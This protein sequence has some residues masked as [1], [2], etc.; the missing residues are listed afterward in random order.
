MTWRPALPQ[1]VAVRVAVCV[2]VC[3]LIRPGALLFCCFFHGLCATTKG[4]QLYAS[5]KESAQLHV[6]QHK[7]TL[8]CV[9]FFSFSFCLCRCHSVWCCFRMTYL[10][11]FRSHAS[12]I[13]LQSALCNKKRIEL[14]HLFGA[15][16]AVSWLHW[17]L[18]DFAVS[19][20]HW[21]LLAITPQAKP[22]GYITVT[23]MEDKSSGLRDRWVQYTNVSVKRIS[24][25]ILDD[26]FYHLSI[27]QCSNCRWNLFVL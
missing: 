21:I 3:R 2:A 18:L 8:G 5:A 7:L 12:Q 4:E 23:S 13:F 25:W 10:I 27:T 24:S 16:F 9:S 22:P 11:Q 15:D 6:R 20:L 19:W 14:L 1:C 26:C 17:I